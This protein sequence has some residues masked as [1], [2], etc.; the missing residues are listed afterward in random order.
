MAPVYTTIFYFI[1]YMLI[2]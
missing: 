1:S 2:E